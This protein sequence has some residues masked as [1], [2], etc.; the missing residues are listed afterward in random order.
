M[1]VVPGSNDVP[2]I[3]AETT[4]PASTLEGVTEVTTGMGF[5]KV[6]TVEALSPVSVSVAVI[7]TLVFAGR[8]SGA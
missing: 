4:E 1:T 2:D 8:L 7:V 3:T 6:R 5:T